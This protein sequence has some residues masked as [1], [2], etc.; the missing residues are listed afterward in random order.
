[1]PVVSQS[2]I[3]PMV[4]VGAET[5]GLAVAHAELVGELARLVPACCAATA[6]RRAPAPRRSRPPAS[7]CMRS[8]R[9]MGSWFSAKPANGPMRAAVRARGGVRVAGHERRDGGGARPTLVGVVGQ[10]E[11]HEQRAEVGVAEAELAEPAGVLG[12][13]LGRVVGVADED[14]LGGEHD[15][16]GVLEPVDVER[17]VVV[18]GTSAG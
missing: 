7:R 3:R 5:D 1:M 2:I 9:S 17:V 12:D 8:T 13:L 16:D 14:L 10:P 6:G 4:P 18:Q 15:L 11:R